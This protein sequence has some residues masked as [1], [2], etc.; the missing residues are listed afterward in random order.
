MVWVIDDFFLSK[1]LRNEVFPYVAAFSRNFDKKIINKIRQ[2][3]GE[4]VKNIHAMARHI[5]IYVKNYLF[6]GSFNTHSLVKI[7]KSVNPWS[8]SMTKRRRIFTD[9]I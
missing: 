1:G 4:G 9:D 6:H 5:R 7:K 2:I 8:G 3:V